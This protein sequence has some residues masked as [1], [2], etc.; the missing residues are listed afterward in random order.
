[1]FAMLIGSCAGEHAAMSLDTNAVPAEELV[2]R[3]NERAAA[4]TSMTGRGSLWYESPAAAGSAFFTIAL[5]KPDSLLVRLKGPFGM[6]VGL[7]FLSRDRYVV[8]NGMQNQVITGVPTMESFRSVIPVDLTREQIL[9]AFS[10]TFSVDP[11][12]GRL[13]R[14]TVD[15]D[16]FLL[17]Y[18]SGPDTTRYWIDPENQL[19]IRTL[20][21]GE[22]GE[23][24]LEATAEN[25]VQQEGA[26]APRNVQIRLSGQQLSIRY[27]TLELNTG[28]PSFAFSIPSGTR[29]INR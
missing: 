26:F 24:L 4:V 22:G 20:V 27:S 21:T 13:V 9:E 18:V 16:A 6:E 19:V 23:T 5:R 7:L 12:R 1:M 10:G 17:A 28:H 3:V 29:T 2:R 8:Y 25:P 15:D 11:S 14:Y